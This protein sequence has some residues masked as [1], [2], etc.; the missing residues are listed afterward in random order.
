MLRIKVKIDQIDDL[1]MA[2]YCA[3]MGV[4]FLGCC[5]AQNQARAL[6]LEQHLEIRNWVE[7]GKWVAEVQN[8]SQIPNYKTQIDALELHSETQ[9]ELCRAYRLPL[10]YR[11]DSS[12]RENFEVLY[13]RYPNLAGFII[14]LKTS[15]LKDLSYLQSLARHER[16][17]LSGNFDKS[18]VAY[19]L[20][21]TDLK[22]LALSYT[23][24]FDQIAEILE[25]LEIED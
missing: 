21:N 19:L 11:F 24:G 4:E 15:D 17:F 1:Q 2:R 3:G 16:V 18:E 8:I 23:T 20:D 9:I 10:F 25:Y 22:G 14:P 5:F 6:T 12:D 7:G 13:E